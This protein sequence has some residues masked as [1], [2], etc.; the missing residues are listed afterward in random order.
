MKPPAFLIFVFFCLFVS[1]C[2]TIYNPATERDEVYFISEETE[3]EIGGNLAKKIVNDNKMVDD[4]ARSDFLK[5]IGNKIAG[6]SDRSSLTYNFYIVDDG[7]MNAFALPGGY[8]FVNKGLIDKTTRDELAFVLA[9]EIGHVTARHSLKRLQASLGLGLLIDI[10]LGSS[11]KAN[12]RQAVD[13]AYGVI[14][15]G[16]SRKDELL[17]DSLG[18]KYVYAAGYD[19]EAAITLL[20][21][22][23]RETDQGYTPIFLR[24]HPVIEDRISNVKDKIKTLNQ[25]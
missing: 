1:G 15:S 19:P 24:S 4:P 18:I 13:I 23:E 20:K 5:K 12:I 14:A 6:A 10:A 11:D 3:I 7:Q 21:N 22:L 17:A 8:I 25:P 9:H 16:Y 2:I